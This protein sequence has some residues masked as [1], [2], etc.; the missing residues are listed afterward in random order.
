MHAGKSYWKRLESERFLSRRIF[1]VNI[2][3]LRKRRAAGA[4]ATV[5]ASGILS[6]LVTITGSLAREVAGRLTAIAA[7]SHRHHRFRRL[8]HSMLCDST[9]VFTLNRK[10]DSCDF[11]NVNLGNLR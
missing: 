4:V 7:I 11:E 3:D 8:P 1:D 5:A 9:R 2:A 10:A 6:R